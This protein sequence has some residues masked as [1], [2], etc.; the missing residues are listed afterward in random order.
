MSRDF[1]AYVKKDN[2]I[3]GKTSGYRIRANKQNNKITQNDDNK[4]MPPS[5]SELTP[6]VFNIW[7]THLGLEASK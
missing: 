3:C 2:T 1:H 7:L 6:M 4:W 5:L